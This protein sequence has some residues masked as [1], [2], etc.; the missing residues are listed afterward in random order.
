MAITYNIMKCRRGWGVYVRAISGED[1]K[2][3]APH[4]K[5][6]VARVKSGR[7]ARKRSKQS[8]KNFIARLREEPIE[9]QR[10]RLSSR[11]ITVAPSSYKIVR[12]QNLKL[13]R[14]VEEGRFI[15]QLTTFNR[16]YAESVALFYSQVREKQSFLRKTVTKYLKVPLENN[17]EH[18]NTI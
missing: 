5:L 2:A 11:W 8:A 7:I 16:T 18:L 10:E 9:V 14:E 4:T 1:L 12:V 15:P 17:V 6:S 3:I 13:F